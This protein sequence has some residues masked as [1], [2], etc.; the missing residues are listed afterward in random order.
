MAGMAWGQMPEP[1]AKKGFGI[2]I[3]QNPDWPIKLRQLHVKWFYTWGPKMPEGIPQGVE[4]I[5]MIWGQWTCNDE[6]MQRLVGEKHKTLL[7]FNEPDQSEQANMSV[8]K[9]L[10]LW[11][12]LMETGMRLGSPAGVHPDGEWMTAFMAEADKRGY[13]IDFITIHNYYGSN[14]KHFLN[15]LEKIRKL[16]N[17]PLWVTEFAV[18]DWGARADKPNQ[19]SPADVYKF[20][21]VVLPSL[22]IL[23]YVERYAWFSAPKPTHALAPSVLFDSDGAL[24]RLGQLYASF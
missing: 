1:S 21:E 24:T 20:M 9:A 5:P 13:R 22:E 12:R 11:P 16:Y 15:R 10:E 23:D 4:Y 19:Y 14:P 6:T 8:E 18:A 17:K 2:T 7:G 3:A